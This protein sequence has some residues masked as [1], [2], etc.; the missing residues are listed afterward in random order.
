MESDFESIFMARIVT[1]EKLREG[2]REQV[3]LDR[4]KGLI[5]LLQD[6]MRALR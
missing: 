6:F 3:K 5:G 1:E 2:Q 4:T